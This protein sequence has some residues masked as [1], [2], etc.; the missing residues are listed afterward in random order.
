M[1]W[2]LKKFTWRYKKNLVIFLLEDIL[3]SKTSAIDN[4]TAEKII[5]L[6]IKSRGNKIT[7]FII[8]D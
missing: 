3:N 1:K 4:K 5:T 6:A 8:K 2:L 7:S